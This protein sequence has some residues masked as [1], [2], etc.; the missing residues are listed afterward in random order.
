MVGAGRLGASLEGGSGMAD[1]DKVLSCV[2]L[3]VGVE[4]VPRCIISSV[5][6]MLWNLDLA[7]LTVD[8]ALV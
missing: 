1:T 6:A 3:S 2:C 4:E 5:S 7:Q 8:A